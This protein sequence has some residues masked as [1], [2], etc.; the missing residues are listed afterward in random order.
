MKMEHA[1]QRPLRAWYV[2]YMSER[3]TRS[4]PE[5]V[6]IELDLDAPQPCTRR[7]RWP[8]RTKC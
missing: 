8:P 5:R 2:R 3:V 6:V 1:L 7:T 4:P